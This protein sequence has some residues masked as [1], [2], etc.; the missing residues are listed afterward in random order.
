MSHKAVYNKA[1]RARQKMQDITKEYNKGKT[2]N[3]WG[4]FLQL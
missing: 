4:E 3:P 2:N 1:M